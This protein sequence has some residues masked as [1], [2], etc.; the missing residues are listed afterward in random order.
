MM[1]A[2]PVGKLREQAKRLEAA[3]SV[4]VSTPTVKAVHELRAATRRVEAQLELLSMRRAKF[5]VGS[6][7]Y[8][9]APAGFATATYI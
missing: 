1:T 2:T 7:R 9:S 8:A 3:L 5:C 6:Q 4:G